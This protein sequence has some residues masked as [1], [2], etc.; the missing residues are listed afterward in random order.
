[1]LIRFTK[2]R[3]AD[4]QPTMT[5]ERDDGTSTWQTGTAFFVAHDITHFA[6]ESTLSI[7]NAFFGLI[8]QGW[9][10]A[11]FAEKAR[12]SAKARP[13]PSEAHFVEILVGILD[14]QRADATLSDQMVIE[15][16]E[17][18]CKKSSITSLTLI[19]EQVSEIKE[20]RDRALYEYG[21]LGPGRTLAL[22]L[23]FR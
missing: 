4:R 21:R 5:I 17:A 9:D 18:A 1:M 3:T 16:A 11:S 20:T 13:L 14:M 2:P 8:N 23:D 15:H 10:I 7:A 22:R 12:G 6:V 19:P